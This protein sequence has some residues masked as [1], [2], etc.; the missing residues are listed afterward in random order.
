MTNPS[1]RRPPRCKDKSRCWDKWLI[2]LV[3]LSLLTFPHYKLK[4][5]ERE[6]IC[7]RSSCKPMVNLQCELVV[8]SSCIVGYQ[9]VP[10]IPRP[11]Q[12]SPSLPFHWHTF[13]SDQLSF[14]SCSI[15]RMLT[16]FPCCLQRHVLLFFFLLN[17]LVTALPLDISHPRSL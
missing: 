5:R 4:S 12:S 10:V 17:N 13:S 7:P 2:L 9:F 1:Q 8:P 6:I 14:P 15:P 3:F 11:S 16:F